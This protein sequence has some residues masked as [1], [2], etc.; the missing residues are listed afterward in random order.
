MSRDRKEEEG[1]GVL[2]ED[3]RDAL[4]LFFVNGKFHLL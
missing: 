3:G 1:A 4:P 2:N